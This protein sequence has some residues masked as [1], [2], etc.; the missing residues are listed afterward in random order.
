MTLLGYIPGAEPLT[1][2]ALGQS[3]A[4]LCFGGCASGLNESAVPVHWS[5]SHKNQF[6]MTLLVP[7]TAWLTPS[8]P[9]ALENGTYRVSVQCVDMTPGCAVRPG[10]VSTVLHLTGVVYKPC[11]KTACGTLVLS[12]VSAAPGTLVRVHGWAPLQQIIGTPF[13]YALVIVPGQ[14]SSRYT[15]VTLVKGRSQ[16]S[17]GTQVASLQQNL[18]GTFSGSFRV[19]ALIEGTKAVTAGAYT[20]ALQAFLDLKSFTQVTFAPAA[21][22][23]AANQT[24]ASLGQLKP[25]GSTWSAAVGMATVTS[26]AGAPNRLA[27]CAVNGEIRL[28]SNGG[29]SWSTVPD[30][31]VIAEAA[32]TAFP[33]A[34][35]GSGPPSAPCTSVLLDAAHPDTVYATFNA[36]DARYQSIPPIFTVGYV[37]TNLGQTWQPVA[38]PTG[39]SLG[40]FAGFQSAGATTL[41]LYQ[42]ANSAG[43]TLPTAVLA[44]RDGG[45]S[46][47]TARLTCPSVGPCL[48]FG[49]APSMIGGMGAAF[50]QAL[51]WSNNAGASWQSPAWPSQVVLNQGPSE[52]VALSST[53]ALLLSASSQYTLRLTSDS[54]QL[55]QNITLP[56]VPDA[57]N[58]ASGLANAVI[59]PSGSLLA[60][61]PNGQSWILLRPGAAAW[62]TVSSLPHGFVS[63]PV[64][65][66]ASLW[67]VSGTSGGQAIASTPLAAIVCQP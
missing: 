40:A 25:L 51:E 19:P 10:E 56:P 33:L 12:S 6:T 61:D 28:S 55:W 11:P 22:K 30:Q 58:G 5:T 67:Y 29:Q 31:A 53:R 63:Q 21:L 20:L 41:A 18:N 7:V 38:P 49:A 60:L 36:E 26:L 50:P 24:W 17:A 14:V 4:N 43:R 39:Y 47:Y 23:V 66:G 46:W 3:Y 37:T 54:G 48:R 9:E 62:C 59:L 2:S 52:L 16:A 42:G 57:Q 64:V 15:A 1:A 45:R 8:G 34:V 32:T 44:T 65:V 27:A 35:F 13:P